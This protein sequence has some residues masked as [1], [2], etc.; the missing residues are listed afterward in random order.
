MDVL[1]TNED[2]NNSDAYK[3]TITQ[4]LKGDISLSSTMID[5][6]SIAGTMVGKLQTNITSE[7]PLSPEPIWEYSLVGDN[8]LIYNEFFTIE[9]DTLRE[10]SCF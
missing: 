2:D 5:E 9:N 1:E 7:P 6:N 3:V 10:Q 8:D 4:V